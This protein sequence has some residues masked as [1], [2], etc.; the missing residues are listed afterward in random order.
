MYAQL[1]SIQ[2]SNLTSF[3]AYSRKQSF[4]FPIHDLIDAIPRTQWTGTDLMTIDVSFH[5]HAAFCVPE[6]SIDALSNLASSGTVL[7]LVL[8]NGR[9]VGDFVIL[10]I[11][12]VHHQG[13]KQG[14]I[15]DATVDVSLQQ[16]YNNSNQQENQLN[17]LNAGRAIVQNSPNILRLQKSQIPDDV[18]TAS[19]Y[20][21]QANQGS[22]LV[23]QTAQK[24]SIFPAQAGTL[25]GIALNGASNCSAGLLSLSSILNSSTYLQSVSPS[26]LNANINAGLTYIT[27]NRGQLSTAN[28]SSIAAFNTGLQSQMELLNTSALPIQ[29]FVIL[30]RNENS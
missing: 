23:N 15:I 2:V 18:L 6:N 17:A 12:E 1:G 25:G 3:T 5:F 29:Q 22:T 24:A 10:S 13:D 19:G 11:N 21:L 28:F 4:K 30:R 26:S 16:Y 27:A 14:N 8:G 9:Y 7:P 20:I